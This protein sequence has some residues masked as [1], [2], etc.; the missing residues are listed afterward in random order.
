MGKLKI[1]RSTIIL[2]LDLLNF[3]PPFPQVAE[4]QQ[5]PYS[6]PLGLKQADMEEVGMDLEEDE[7]SLQDDSLEGSLGNEILVFEEDSDQ[8][9]SSSIQDAGAL[10]E[11]SS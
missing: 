10:N 8:M 3:F 6:V 1:N 5:F 7:V 9:D 4:L 11:S 2:I